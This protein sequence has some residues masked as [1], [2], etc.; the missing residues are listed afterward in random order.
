MGD[1]YCHIRVSEAEIEQSS[2]LFFRSNFQLEIEES[3]DSIKENY[4]KNLSIFI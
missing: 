4:M 1:E 3:P 2:P